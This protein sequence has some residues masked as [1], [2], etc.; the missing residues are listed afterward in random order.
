LL[1]EAV[2][3]I[4]LLNFVNIIIILLFRVTTIACIMNDLFRFLFLALL[5]F[6]WIE[7]SELLSEDDDSVELD[8]GNWPHNRLDLPPSLLCLHLL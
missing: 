6:P 4:E 1:G 7:V 2:I 5:H 3:V 8:V